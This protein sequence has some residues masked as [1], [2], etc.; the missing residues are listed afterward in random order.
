MGVFCPLFAPRRMR[1]ELD[2]GV[3]QV[4]LRCTC[5]AGWPVVETIFCVCNMANQFSTSAVM[6]ASHHIPYLPPAV[7]NQTNRIKC[8]TPRGSN[9]FGQRFF[10][11]MVLRGKEMLI[12]VLAL[13]R[14]QEGRMQHEL[15]IEN[16]G[17]MHS[18]HV[19][20]MVPGD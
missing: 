16:V 14:R 19:L 13:N 18:L 17:Q 4:C 9:T 12:W 2:L 11:S 3:G 1:K 15:D 8:R 7:R 10:G 6:A 5:C 20:C